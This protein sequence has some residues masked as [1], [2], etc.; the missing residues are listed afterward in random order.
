MLGYVDTRVRSYGDLYNQIHME[1]GGISPVINVYLNSKEVKEYR[2][3]FEWK[4]KAMENNLSKAVALLKEIIRES[5][6]TDERRLYEILAEMK[7]R[8]QADMVQAAH[9]VAA[10]RAT[11]YFS[12]SGAVIECRSIGWSLIWKRILKI[13]RKNYGRNWK[14]CATFYSVRGI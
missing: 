9:R 6:F 5:L 1:T 14:G 2:L 13:K 4:V 7:S 8:M 12:P 3:T 10:A 11:S